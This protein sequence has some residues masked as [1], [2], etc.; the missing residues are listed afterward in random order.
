MAFVLPKIDSLKSLLTGNAP[1]L[2]TLGFKL[3]FLQ[4]FTFD[5]ISD[6]SNAKEGLYRQENL[7]GNYL[8]VSLVCIIIHRKDIGNKKPVDQNLVFCIVNK[9]FYY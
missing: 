7:M 3:F 2:G 6:D 5:F 4:L 9:L 1:C 8:F